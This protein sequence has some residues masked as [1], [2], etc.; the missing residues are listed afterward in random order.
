MSKETVTKVMKYEL[1]YLEGCGSFQGMQENVWAI[2]R[3]TRE[4]LNRT[5]QICYHWDYLNQEQYK[6]TGEY[7]DVYKETGYKRL[8]GYIYDCIKG[9]CEDMAA[10]NINTTIQKAWSKYTSSKADLLRG[11]MSVP[12]YKKDQPLLIHKQSITF[13]DKE[14][15]PEVEMSLFSTK[16]KQRTGFP[17][18]VRFAVKIN[19]GT[20]RSIF[21]RVV[22]RQY[23]YG[24]CQLVYDRPKWFLLLTYSFVP[25]K[26]TLDENRIL[27]VDLGET[28][29]VYAS[30]W[31]EYGSFKIEGGEVTEFAKKW[32]ARR[33]SLQKQA[34]Y[35]GD[36]RVGHGTKTRVSNVYQAKEHIANFRDTINHRYSKALI[37]Y[38]VKKNCGVIQ[39]EELTGIKDDSEFPKFLRHWTY[40]DLQQKIE[41]KAKEYDISVKKVNPQYTSQR[42][43]KCGNIDKENRKTQA[44]F[45]CTQCGFSANADFN[46]SQNLAIK[47][48]D[49]LIQKSLSAKEKKT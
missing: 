10:S 7:L 24:Q 16:F 19:D 37:E 41:A 1:R 13:F 21:T 36:G 17:T 44:N 18:R 39:M 4:L 42:C 28:N 5:I 26:H 2:Q 27:G 11:N 14:S 46:A 38:A 12:S 3:K 48:I 20:Q 43:S 47:D 22:N 32:E 40:Y 34:A 6:K 15:G 49:K 23:G 29:A 33:H 30:V 31:D 25:E 45:K 9:N 35:C 8:D